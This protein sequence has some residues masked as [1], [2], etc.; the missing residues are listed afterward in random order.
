MDDQRKERT[1]IASSEFDWNRAEGTGRFASTRISVLDET[2]RD[3][4]QSPSV[5]EPRFENKLK[6]LVAMSELGIDI[7]NIGIPSVSPRAFEDCLL[8]CKEVARTKVNIRLA[9]AGRTLVGDITP[10]LELSQRAGVP[11]EVYAFIGSSPIRQYVEGWDVP[12]IAR[13]S[14]EAIDVAV[15]AGLD[16]VYVTEDT[17]RSHPHALTTLFQSAIDH[18]AKRLCL[19]D[20]VGHATAAGVRRLL[21]F[22]K[23][24]LARFG[25]S[26]IGIDWHGHNDRGLALANALWAMECGADRV[27]ATALGIGERVGNVPMEALLRNMRLLGLHDRDLSPLSRY[28]ELC[29]QVLAWPQS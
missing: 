29:S 12:L 6:L 26:H 23:E 8:L 9:C 24:V 20:T 5:T 15:K 25:A 22:T 2:L 7:A 18:G 27:H 13:Q 3:G 10:I 21:R 1:H 16:V 28:T 17:T 11:V 19:A 4:L 14:A